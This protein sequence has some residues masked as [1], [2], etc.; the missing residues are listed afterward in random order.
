MFQVSDKKKRNTFLMNA[1]L[2]ICAIAFI[3]AHSN[4]HWFSS[5]SHPFGYSSLKSHD[6]ASLSG[7]ETHGFFPRSF[8]NHRPER[9]N[10][11]DPRGP[12][13]MLGSDGRWGNKHRIHHQRIPHSMHSED[14][15]YTRHKYHKGGHRETEDFQEYE[16]NR[17]LRNEIEHDEEL[18][19]MHDYGNL[20]M[21]HHYIK[22]HGASPSKIIDEL[23]EHSDGSE[24]PIYDQRYMDRLRS[25]RQRLVMP[26]GS[27][28]ASSG[29]DFLITET[30]SENV[31]GLGYNRYFLSSKAY[32]LESKEKLK[33][34]VNL[35]STDEDYLPQFVIFK[36]NMD[37]G[38]F[39]K[40]EP[41]SG[42]TDPVNIYE[43]ERC[44]I[45]IIEVGYD[46]TFSPDQF[47]NLIKNGGFRLLISL[48]SKSLLS[49]FI[50]P[51]LTV[52]K[53]K[54]KLPV[55]EGKSILLSASWLSNLN[56]GKL[57]TKITPYFDEKNGSVTIYYNEG[58]QAYG[59]VKRRSNIRQIC[60]A[61]PRQKKPIQGREPITG[62]YEWDIESKRMCNFTFLMSSFA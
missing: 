41:I 44:N 54:G 43:M 1:F 23:N 37:T 8:S 19:R 60:T 62:H 14:P 7:H 25:R 16:N 40:V 51:E 55:E 52:S 6:S 32:K 61:H 48:D 4:H 45:Y 5:G 10:S 58:S 27:K 15:R 49:Y 13:L 28:S 34:S 56:H 50:K 57:N 29:R 26:K 20:H 24:S 53:Y 31:A 33:I 12:H 9:L 38:T 3:K 46:P 59:T 42:P 35:L 17:D 22:H 30:T 39:K 47:G 2:V 36:Y 11:K 21:N 18:E